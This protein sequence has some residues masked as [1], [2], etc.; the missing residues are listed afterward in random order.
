MK[1]NIFIII[2]A[3]FIAGIALFFVAKNTGKMIKE[4]IESSLG[5]NITIEN[6]SLSWNGVDL[7][8]VTV[9]AAEEVVLKADRI[10]LKVDFF[11]FLKKGYAL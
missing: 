1:K 6:I 5:K 3:L 8:G 9:I 10:G 7:S 4:K 11:G 2:I